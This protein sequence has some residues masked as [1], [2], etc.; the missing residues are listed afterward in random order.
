[1]KNVLFIFFILIL[2]ATT[3]A[4]NLVPN[5]SFEQYSSCPNIGFL[6]RITSWTG[7]TNHTGTPDGYNVCATP[8]GG[9]VPINSFGYQYAHSGVGYAGQYVYY[10]FGESHEYLSVE[11]TDSMQQGLTYHISFYYS[12]SNYVSYTIS[13]YG[14]YLSK[15]KPTG[16]GG[17][18]ALPYT[19]QFETSTYLTDTAG[20]TLVE[21]D[22]VAAGG[23]KFLVMGNFRANYSSDTLRVPT[24]IT[25]PQSSAYF[26]IDDVSIAEQGCKGI[27]GANTVCSKD[28]LTLFTA[29]DSVYGWA[30]SLYP[31]TILSTDTFL[32]VAPTS[33]TTFILYTACDTFYR[34]IKVFHAPHINVGNDT[35]V[36]APIHFTL[37]TGDTAA[38][39]LWNTGDTTAQITVTQTGLYTVKATT[40]NSTC[41]TTDS[42]V[43]DTL[44][45]PYLQ[46]GAPN[47]E[48]CAGNPEIFNLSGKGYQQIVWQDGKQDSVYTAT[49]S[50][51]YY[52][53]VSNGQC[54]AHD[55]VLLTFHSPVPH[56]FTSP[57]NL[58]AGDTLTLDLSTKA[59]TALWNN[60]VNAL[61]YQITTS[62]TCQFM[63]TDSFCT[64]TDSVRVNFT[65]LPVALLPADTELCE[66]RQI[67]LSP[68]TGNYTFA[69][70]TGSTDSALLVS[71]AGTY[72]VSV[73]NSCGTAVD[74]IEITACPCRFQI[75]NVF[76]PDNN[77][78][79]DLFTPEADCVPYNYHL[80][81]FN[82]WGEVMF[83]STS[84]NKSWDGTTHNK[85]A[86]EG[87]YFWI[88]EYK[89]GINAATQS[90]K[91]TL[92]L[93]R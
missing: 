91:G 70:N 77:L 31:A 71:T 57:Y 6:N 67:L 35:A 36:C 51:M 47:I 34:P 60:N 25:F 76:T 68:A 58:C 64:T 40:K 39:F 72:F 78:Q 49:G 16:T 32:K 87:I 62:G 54:K 89:S 1:M 92:T 37:Y 24:G 85:K 46:L 4:Q 21:F 41:Y 53:Q 17:F 50:G 82:R 27:K 48:R 69:W 8:A 3:R 43:L 84:I 61:T 86:S 44:P 29:N 81:I 5:G 23:E 7:V 10:K 13:H 56:G 42:L 79:N 20:W 9:G 2:P 80:T 15:T 63:Y 11:L 73:T 18:S 75:P 45:S 59:L 26:L 83:E 38:S 55:T 90:H 88:L 74:S 19:P 52:V 93:L 30:D 22:Y 33:N 12:L 14:V 66:G 28:T 65:Q